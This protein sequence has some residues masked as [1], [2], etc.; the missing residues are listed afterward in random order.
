[1]QALFVHDPLYDLVTRSP[2]MHGRESFV[3][4]VFKSELADV[5]HESSR[6]RSGSKWHR[7]RKAE[8]DNWQKYGQKLE[9][10]LNSLD[11]EKAAET[12]GI[13]EQRRQDIKARIIEK[14]WLARDM[15]P[16]PENCYQW[17]QL[18]EQP[19]PLT[20]RTWANLYPK[21]LP[22][23]E[24]NHEY[25][26]RI[27]RLKRKQGRHD[28]V[29]D[30]VSQM[31]KGL[32]PL[33]QV[34]PKQSAQTEDPDS[35]A[36]SI[37]GFSTAGYRDITIDMLFPSSDELFRWP[38]IKRI[39]KA[40]TSPEE[41]R[42]KLEEIQDEFDQAVAE[43]RENVEQDLI[44]IWNTEEEPKPKRASSGRPVK[45]DPIQLEL[46][47]F[48]VTVGK[49]DGTTTTDLSDLSPSMQLLLRA[50]TIFK[51]HPVHHSYPALVP[52]AFPSGPI[53]GSPTEW[54]SRGRWKAK[55][56]S[57]DNK[58]SVV[59][60]K[61]LARIGRPDA[62]SAETKAFGAR[63]QCGRC[64]A[65]SPET[66]SGLVQHYAQEERQWKQAQEKIPATSKIVYRNTHDLGP[67]DPRP[68][69]RLVPPQPSPSF[70]YM[71]P[72]MQC[73][74]CEK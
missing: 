12:I 30:M 33:V 14:G 20:N 8:V 50:D 39:V 27:D 42:V 2:M 25:H 37:T 43:W 74:W 17:D 28:M 47:E 35:D 59:A 13:K 23:L 58:A 55:R 49:P 16:A 63:F 9:N 31:R 22:L 64:A 52:H 51:G 15:K 72:M 1:T 3:Y 68:F 46:P 62:T 26:E 34:T 41:A 53:G 19:K 21:L 38:M 56:I 18:V 10:F 61:L 57:R 5:Q 66:W 65:G 24:S 45:A 6:H 7:A 60:K 44:E 73:I 70:Q 54:N 11:K 29:Q 32:P 40:D 67:G 48:I 71:K 69:A 36:D 4:T